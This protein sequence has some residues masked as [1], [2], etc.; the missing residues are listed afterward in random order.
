MKYTDLT[1][2]IT[3]N[4]PVYPGTEKPVLEK[5]EI[6]GY[7][8]TLFHMFSHTGTHMDAPYHVFKD[9]RKLEDYSI[10]EFT[11]RAAVIDIPQGTKTIEPEMLKSAEG[12]GFVLLRTGWGSKW[13][14][15]EYFDGFPV[16]SLKAAEY[17]AGL[18]LKGIGLDCISVDEVGMNELPVHRVILGSGMLI[19]ENL[20]CLEM[21][22]AEVI[23]TARPLKYADSDG[24]SVR[25][26]ASY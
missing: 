24:C 16:L 13:G 26:F 9:G 3:E 15:D 21:L 1:Y 5:L 20:A 17:L 22:P 14:R 19:I 11:G 4:M 6:D 8:E 10:E 25:A 7:R 2:T 12:F 23:F 18:R